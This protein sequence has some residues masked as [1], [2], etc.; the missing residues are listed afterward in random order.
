MAD[1]RPGWAGIEELARERL[2]FVP[3]VLD[4]DLLRPAADA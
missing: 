1:V 4:R 2:G 3:L